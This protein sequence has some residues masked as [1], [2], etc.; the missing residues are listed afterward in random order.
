MI[1]ASS[2]A[3]YHNAFWSEHAPTSE[4]FV[5]RLN[6]EWTERW[7]PPL[8][9]PE[10]HIRADLVAELAFS[11]FCLRMW[12]HASGVHDK[13][14]EETI[15]RLTPLVHDPSLLKQ[16]ISHV[17]KGES[18]EIFKNLYNYF[19]LRGDLIIRPIFNGCGYLDKSEGDIISKLCLFEVKTV[20]R[21]F[22]STDIRQLVT[23]CALNHL[24]CQY[25]I[26]NIGI[27]NPRRGVY[28]ELPVEM[29]CYEISGRSSQELFDTII[30]A[31]SS[32]DISR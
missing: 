6:L 4:H 9:K 12:G 5:R 31:I 25:E 7:A 17:E 14:L 11:E 21:A 8:K 32:G 24:S 30:H 19:S 2:F 20:N 28:F 27:F 3:S 26:Q 29:I 15:R 22:R 1:D 18:Q 16:P 10:D 23:Y 13:A